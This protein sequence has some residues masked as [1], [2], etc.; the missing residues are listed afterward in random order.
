M[1]SRDALTAAYRSDT[2]LVTTRRT[3]LVYQV[4]QVRTT[5][6]WAASSDHARID[7]DI[8]LHLRHVMLENLDPSAHV[9][10]T[11]NDWLSA[12]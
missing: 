7:V 12:A 8:E 1:P 10:Q 5:H 3:Y 6:P 9:W 11:H 4:L 2:I